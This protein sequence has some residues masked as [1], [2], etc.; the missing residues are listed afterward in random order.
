MVLTILELICGR[1]RRVGP[2]GAL[3]ALLVGV[4][5]ELPLVERLAVDQAR[6]AID[7]AITAQNRSFDRLKAFEPSRDTHTTHTLGGGRSD[8]LETTK[9]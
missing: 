6:S 3:A 2:F 7:I 5:I 9:A 4:Y 8:E 1:L